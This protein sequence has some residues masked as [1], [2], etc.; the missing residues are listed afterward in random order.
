MIVI[1]DVD[2]IVLSRVI[3]NIWDLIEIK[4]IK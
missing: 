4:Q 1:Q 3:A 2:V